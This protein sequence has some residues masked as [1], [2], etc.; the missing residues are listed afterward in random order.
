MSVEEVKM[1][2]FLFGDEKSPS[3]N[4]F[5]TIFFQK[6]W[7]IFAKDLWEVVEESWSKGY[8]FKELN[9]F[10]IALIPKKDGTRT[11][12]D[13]RPISLCNTIYKVISEDC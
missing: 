5:S 12:D 11:F 8:M 1:A 2:L 13:I 10:F 3:P 7:D 4:G 6:L 9:N